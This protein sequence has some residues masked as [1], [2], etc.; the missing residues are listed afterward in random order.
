MPL[1]EFH[2]TRCDIDRDLYFKAD[3]RK[4]PRCEQ[5]NELM[6]R[7]F[8]PLAVHMP[9]PKPPS[10]CVETGNELIRPDT[11][12]DRYKDVEREIHQVIEQAPDLD[13]SGDCELAKLRG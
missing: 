11:Q 7:V 2:C 3:E 13:G 8:T 10:G 9:R 5:C 4:E 1:Y 6:S 12:P